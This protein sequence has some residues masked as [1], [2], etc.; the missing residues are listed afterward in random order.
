MRGQRSFKL[1]ALVFAT[2]KLLRRGQREKPVS[3]PRHLCV[4]HSLTLSSTGHYRDDSWLRTK[5]D[6]GLSLVLALAAR[7][8]AFTCRMVGCRHRAMD[9]ACSEPRLERLH[10]PAGPPP[11]PPR[12]KRQTKS[13]CTSVG[14]Q[15]SLLCART[16][17][18]MAMQL[19][20]TR[21]GKQGGSALELAVR[22][23]G[24]LRT[25]CTATTTILPPLAQSS[26]YHH[27]PFG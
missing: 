9:L 10:R 18:A 22:G 14:K 11:L 8:A 1:Q 4:I 26:I 7:T 20:A 17:S 24:P 6:L 16:R 13:R 5:R 2:T 15:R 23:F 19:H 21:L 12:S 3:W 25:L 27:P